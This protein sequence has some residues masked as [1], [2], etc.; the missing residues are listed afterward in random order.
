MNKIQHYSLPCW[1]ELPQFDLY[2]DQLISVVQMILQPINLN[3]RMTLTKSMINN[4]TKKKLLPAPI[5]KKY[6]VHHVARVLII[7]LLKQVFS[8]SHIDEK[9]TD[10]IAQVDSKHV[11]DDF[12]RYF[13]E[14]WQQLVEGMPLTI[15]GESRDEMIMKSAICS[16]L[17]KTMCEQLLQH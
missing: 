9:V 12:V 17:T 13:N 16:V 8:L 10:L 1:E 4:Y 5:G 14:L 11:Y 15:T 7:T 6:N 3:Q 2:A